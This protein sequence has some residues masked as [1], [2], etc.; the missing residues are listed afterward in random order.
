MFIQ[1]NFN[2]TNELNIYIYAFYTP[3]RVRFGEQIKRV[4][5]AE[6]FFSRI[7]ASPD[8]NNLSAYGKPQ[9][10]FLCH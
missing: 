5:F 1:C 8:E 9:K 6:R 10:K 4:S 3:Q 7:K 2:Y